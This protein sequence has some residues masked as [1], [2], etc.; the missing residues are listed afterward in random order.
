MNYGD[1]RQRENVALAVIFIVC[2]AEFA[3]V[4]WG[5]GIPLEPSLEAA[6]FVLVTLQASVKWI[7]G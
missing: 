3:V 5:R 2:I 6:G 4:F 7:L 1:A